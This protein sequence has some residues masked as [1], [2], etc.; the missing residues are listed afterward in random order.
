MRGT[1][2]TLGLLL[3]LLSAAP[4]NASFDRPVTDPGALYALDTARSYW[5]TELPCVRMLW[6]TGR[7]V[8]AETYGCDIYLFPNWLQLSPGER[9]ETIVH[10]YGHLLG[11]G[12]T[13][14]VRSI[15][16]PI[17]D[18]RLV[19]ACYPPKGHLA[20]VERLRCAARR[21]PHIRS[22]VHSNRERCGR[23]TYRGRY[24]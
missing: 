23:R 6:D 24:R 9:C 18:D 21:S 11:H 4:A 5:G 16:S 7:D 3:T 19:P 13:T 17:R 14:S 8:A 1:K 10:E 20:T 22:R 2:W 15:M 12:H